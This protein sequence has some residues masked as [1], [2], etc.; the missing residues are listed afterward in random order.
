M[1]A[2]YD[3]MTLEQLAA[4]LVDQLEYQQKHIKF[5]SDNPNCLRTQ[6]EGAVLDRFKYLRGVK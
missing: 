6:M 5:T 4:D 1:S 3:T 2:E